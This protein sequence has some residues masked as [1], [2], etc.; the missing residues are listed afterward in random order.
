MYI[1]IQEKLD[2]FNCSKNVAKKKK[3]HTQLP[4]LAVGALS[5]LS[6]LT[7][8]DSRLV[9]FSK[10]ASKRQ[11]ESGAEKIKKLRDDAREIGRASCRERV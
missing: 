5:Y 6:G 9:N 2:I 7:N 4:K 8:F 1:T 11:Q 10:I 3:I